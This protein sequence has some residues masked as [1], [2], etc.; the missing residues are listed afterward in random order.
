MERI[1]EQAFFAVLTCIM[2]YLFRTQ[3]VAIAFAFADLGLAYNVVLLRILLALTR[4]TLDDGTCSM[5]SSARQMCMC[6]LT[7][8]P[9]LSSDRQRV[10]T[11]ILVLPCLTLD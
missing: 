1:D 2:A 7:P 4:L 3:V 6:L 8:K 10:L 9:D 5:C 11:S